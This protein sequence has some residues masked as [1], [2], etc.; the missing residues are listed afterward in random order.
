M[1]VLAHHKHPERDRTDGVRFVSMNELFELS[2][3]ITLHAPLSHENR[4]I[5][6]R[7]LLNKMK[8]KSILIN[9][10]RGGLI[11][12]DDLFN[13][14]NSHQEST[15]ALDVLSQE[16]PSNNHLLIGLD[17]CIIT[18]HIG[19]ATKES[20]ARLIEI[21]GANI[22]AFLDGQPRNIVT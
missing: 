13:Y 17:N 12:E 16:P 1:K 19:W 4:L 20:R 15:A 7:Q 3:I 10:G 9:T 6:D 21:V 8:P 18:P 22:K 11:N 2:D 5:V 14:L